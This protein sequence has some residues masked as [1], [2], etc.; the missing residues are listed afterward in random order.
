LGAWVTLGVRHLVASPGSR[1]TPLL[2][3]AWALRERL[4][5]HVVVDE[6]AAAFFALGLARRA[7]Q[8]VALVCT[9]GSAGAHYLP[10]VIEAH[11]GGVPLLVVTADRPPELHGAGAPQ[12]TEQTRLFGA[13]VRAAVDLGPPPADGRPEGPWVEAT[14]ARLLDLAT[15]PPAGPVHVNAPFREPLW[16]PGLD[17]A[18]RTPA[19]GRATPRVYR[20]RRTPAPEEVAHVARDLAAARRGVIVCGPRPPSS[21][22]DD[23]LPV[24]LSRLSRSLGWPILAEPASQLRFGPPASGGDPATPPVVS[25]ADALLRVPEVARAMAPER[26]LL[27]GA[28]P[29]SKPLARWLADRAR[30][31]TTVVAGP[32][33]WQDPAHLARERLVGDDALVCE[34]LAAAL[35]GARG[36]CPPSWAHRWRALDQAARIALDRWTDDDGPAWEGAVARWVAQGVPEGGALHLGNSMPIRDV[37]TF[38]P[39]RPTAVPVLVSRGVNGIDGALSTVLGEAAARPDRPFVALLGDLTFLHDL[40]ALVPAATRTA[41]AT[42]IVVR[43]GGGGIFSTLPIRAHDPPGGDGPS[44]FRALFLTPHDADLGALCTAAGVRWRRVHRPAALPEALARD[45]QEP[46]LGVLEVPVDLAHNLT[47]HAQAFAAVREAA[48]AAL[49]TL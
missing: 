5:V 2:L 28:P 40:G 16:T 44:A 36:Q 10:A 21:R 38:A 29:T 24:A 45:A 32:G 4:L 43:N 1:N 18:A 35:E 11:E 3:A 26:V 48:R 42:V 47:R 27:L 33:R 6:R 22:G 39:P 14:A 13:H 31:R 12:T 25:T 15:G 7:A 19:W 9:S 41:R 37:D 30:G 17:E 46:G 34:A 49:V 20:A 23:P 8:P